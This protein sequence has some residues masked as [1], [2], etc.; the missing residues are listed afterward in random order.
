MAQN[1][2]LM[3]VLLKE[4]TADRQKFIMGYALAGEIG[5]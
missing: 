3:E 1:N 2:L 4:L 5:A